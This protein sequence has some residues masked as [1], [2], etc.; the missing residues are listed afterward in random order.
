MNKEKEFGREIPIFVVEDR[1]MSEDGSAVFRH[2]THITTSNRVLSGTVVEALD[3][4]GNPTYHYKPADFRV[5]DRRIHI[6][7]EA[8]RY[9]THIAD[10]EVD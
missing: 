10:F 7:F 4:N 6:P 9:W 8:I 5:T 3:E 1:D 2:L